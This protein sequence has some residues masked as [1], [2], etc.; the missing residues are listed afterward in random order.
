MTKF[1]NNR[2][3]DLGITTEM[4]HPGT[5]QAIV[6]LV[7]GLDRVE[8]KIQASSPTICMKWRN[9]AIH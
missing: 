8:D 2:K 9:G 6:T 4:V 5:G 1:E 3:I 7:S